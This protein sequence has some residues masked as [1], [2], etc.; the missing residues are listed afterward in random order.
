MDEAQLDM[1]GML[2]GGKPPPKID[3][4]LTPEQIF[5]AEE[6]IEDEIPI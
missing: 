5:E 2:G 1:F 4:L 3:P 6:L